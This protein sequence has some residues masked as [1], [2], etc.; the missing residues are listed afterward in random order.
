MSHHLQSNK[1]CHIMVGHYFMWLKEAVIGLS[2]ETKSCPPHPDP[3]PTVCGL[4]CHLTSSF[5]AIIITT[6]TKGLKRTCHTQQL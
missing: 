5:T 3:L 1:S 6:A 2:L 4:T